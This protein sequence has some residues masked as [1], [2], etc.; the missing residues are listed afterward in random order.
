[1]LLFVAGLLFFLSRRGRSRRLES[2]GAECNDA[3]IDLEDREARKR[4][5]GG[6]RWELWNL[7]VSGAGR[8]N[9]HALAHR[10]VAI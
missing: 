8:E 4:C 5:D 2:S 9:R 1:M 7:T 10:R 6:D 3:G